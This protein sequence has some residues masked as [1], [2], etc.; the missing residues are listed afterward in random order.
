MMIKYILALY[1]LMGS[2][3]VTNA[4][5]NPFY[6]ENTYKQQQTEHWLFT[7]AID[8][9]NG[10][11]NFMNQ[12]PQQLFGVNSYY[13]SQNNKVFICGGATQSVVPQSVCRWFNVSSGIYESAASLP[14]G[15]W[16]G[17][18]V[19]VRDSLYLI[20]SVDSTFNT[21][22]GLIF[23]YSLNQ[24]S[25]ILKDTMP[26]PFVHECAVCVVNDSLIVTIGGSTNAFLNPVN[27]V[28]VYNPRYNSWIVSTPYPV[29]VTTAQAGAY[30]S[31]DVIIVLGG[32]S[33]GNLNSVYRGDLFFNTPDSILINWSLVSTTDSTFRT[34][35]YRVAG[36]TWNNYMLF[37]P[38]MNGANAVNQIWGLKITGDTLYTWSNFL[39][40]T[41]DTAGNISS[42]G[43]K[44]GADTNYFFL[45]GGFR[46]PNVVS[47]AQKYTF[48]TP[49]PPI[50]IINSG[51]GIPKSFKLFQNY[52]NP[53]NPVTKIKFNIPLLRGVPEGR[54]VFIQLIVYDILGRKITTLV[55]E[56]LKAGSYIADFDG[57]NLSSGL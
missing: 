2:I 46:N 7:E 16:S 32:Y 1:V 38:A 47:S 56:E 8:T 36:A 26:A 50:G 44:S 19:R 39:P 52:P 15:R 45:F 55:N 31:T 13:W 21:A 48:A 12:M 14:E 30:D 43:V 57:T 35:V 23:K 25:W 10:Y 18:L 5:N 20:G 11:W 54:G 24:N 29:N 27:I 53:F 17:K 22:D 34:G 9:I 4:Q 37:G 40:K 6:A 41:I 3:Y 49:P 33:A 42:Y 28:R 51:N